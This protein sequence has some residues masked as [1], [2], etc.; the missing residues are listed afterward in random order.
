MKTFR[1]VR[2]RLA[3]R[4]VRLSR[5]AF[6]GVLSEES[7]IKFLEK[8][9]PQ[10]NRILFQPKCDEF[11]AESSSFRIINNEPSGA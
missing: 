8:I 4:K 1:T 11:D 6:R 9:K 5:F 3:A 2:D 7:L 10:P